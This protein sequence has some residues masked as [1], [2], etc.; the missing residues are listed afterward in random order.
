MAN[1][2]ARGIHLT[3]R[4]PDDATP[5]DIDT[6][7][8]EPEDPDMKTIKSCIPTIAAHGNAK[9]RHLTKAG[10]SL[11]Y[12]YIYIY[13][14]TITL[15]YFMCTSICTVDSVALHYADSANLF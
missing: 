5:Y 2:T 3:V 10:M 15:C 1:I 9:E 13:I 8:P 12:V 4:H 11:K 14:H 7:E 6:D